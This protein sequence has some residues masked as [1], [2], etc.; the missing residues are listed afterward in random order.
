[1]STSIYINN[2]NIQYAIGEFKGKKINIEEFGE[3]PLPEETLMNEKIFN[4]Q[5]VKAALEQLQIDSA[6]IVITGSSAM[7]KI[8]VIPKMS[9]TKTLRWMRGEFQEQDQDGEE[10]YLFDY[11]LIAPNEEGGYI[12]LLCAIKKSIIEQYIN[13]FDELGIKI[14]GIDIGIDTHMKV[15]SRLPELKNSTFIMIHIVGQLIE[16]SLYVE[17]KF[18]MINRIRLINP[19]DSNEAV[20]EIKEVVSKVMQFNQA[21]RKNTEI[22]AIYLSG[23]DLNEN[24][25]RALANEYSGAIK[26]ISEVAEGLVSVNDI[27]FD[28]NKYLCVVGNLIRE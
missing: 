11:A 4:E 14:E 1:M 13:I 18:N 3:I 23:V 25:Y 7:T 24:I 21:E 22:D 20:D 27:R 26:K 6:N 8:R 9:V 16:T 15:V 12:A 5:A 2:H 10:S 28:I 17:G 19:K